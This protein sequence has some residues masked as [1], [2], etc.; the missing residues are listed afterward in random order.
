MSR[1]GRELCGQVP[2]LTPRAFTD[3][4]RA[5]ETHWAGHASAPLS[6]VVFAARARSGTAG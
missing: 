4:C 1:L 6:D 5:V 3:A 2:G